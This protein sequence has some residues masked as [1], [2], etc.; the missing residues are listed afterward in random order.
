MR[1]ARSTKKMYREEL[2]RFRRRVE[3]RIRLRNS[4]RWI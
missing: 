3:K 2:K 4:S 1:E